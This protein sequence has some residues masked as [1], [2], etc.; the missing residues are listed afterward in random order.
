MRMTRKNSGSVVL[1]VVGLLTIIAMLGGTFVLIARLDRRQSKAIASSAPFRSIADGILTMIVIDRF[2]DLHINGDGPYGAATELDHLIDYA[3]D[4]VDRILASIATDGPGVHM[5]QI[6]ALIGTVEVDTDG[7]GEPDSVLCDTGIPAKEGETYFVAV[8]VI[9]G[10][11]L[12][13]TNIAYF[14]E[15]ASPTTNTKTLSVMN[16][17]LVPVLGDAICKDVRDARLGDY[18][19]VPMIAENYFSWYVIR[20]LNIEGGVLF[21]TFDMSDMLAIRWFGPGQTECGRLYHELGDKLHATREYLTVWSSARTLLP[22][23]VMNDNTAQTHKAD[24]NKSDYEELFN[25]FYN[26]I[27]P[28]SILAQGTAAEKE[29][30]RTRHAAQLAV[31]VMDFTDKDS[32]VTC[33][34]TDSSGGGLQAADGTPVTVYG[35]ERQPFVTEAFGKRYKEVTEDGTITHHYY[36]AVELFNPYTTPI[37]LTGYNIGGASL[38]G[39]TIAAGMRVVLVN[40]DAVV[41][42]NAGAKKLVLGLDL[43]GGAVQVTRTVGGGNIVIAQIPAISLPVPEDNKKKT[44]NIIWH[45]KL[46][47]ARYTQAIKRELEN[48]DAHDYTNVHGS[49]MTRALSRLGQLNTDIPTQALPPCPVYVRNNM[50]VSVG[51]LCRIFYIG[52]TETESLRMQLGDAGRRAAGRLAANGGAADYDNNPLIPD[53][54]LGAILPNYLMVAS[55]LDDE[56]DNDGVDGADPE[57]DPGLEDSVYG[58]ISINAAPAAVLQCLP[59]LA[60]EPDIAD[61]IIAH[62]ANNGGFASPGEVAIP[63]ATAGGVQNNYGKYPPDNYALVGPTDDDGLSVAGGARVDGDMIKYHTRYSWLVNNITVRSDVF[64]A[65]IRV[66]VGPDVAATRGVRHY[67]AFIDRSNCRRVTDRP[68]V[69]MFAQAY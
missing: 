8:R 24:L 23:P 5:S 53:I 16:T 4:D 2:N 3:D 25:A 42:N 44:K 59:G 12:V 29:R 35:I 28:G 56:V 41:V 47:D 7:D 45:D 69:R 13:N 51:D 46:Q 52:P 62:R 20:P 39:T 67:V 64:I 43:S 36:Y 61:A 11:G 31:N 54:P 9:D 32:D 60:N 34:N 22:V 10:C 26:A 17:S 40:K 49:N 21:P 6:G 30:N 55:P 48:D 27:P 19:P 14:P 50:M 65:Y 57:V 18:A 1:L 37:V 38:T 15:E 58:Q 68:M 66:Q 63:L 33:E